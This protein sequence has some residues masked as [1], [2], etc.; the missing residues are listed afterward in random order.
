M[1][2]LNDV[3]LNSWRSITCIAGFKFALN[4]IQFFFSMFLRI[5]KSF[6]RNLSQIQS[7]WSMNNERHTQYYCFTY[8]KTMSI[9]LLF[10]PTSL[11]TTSNVHQLYPMFSTYLLT[12]FSDLSTYLSKSDMLSILSI[13]TSF[14]AF[15][16]ASFVRTLD[17]RLIFSAAMADG[18]LSFY[19]AIYG[20]IDLHASMV[21]LFLV[22]VLIITF[23]L[24]DSYEKKVSEKVR[25]NCRWSK[26]CRSF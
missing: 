13:L 17:M 4:N 3:K 15:L 2:L 20:I 9:T 14:V 21:A 23:P 8:A 6:W 24:I 5:N 10:R 19:I 25:W 7:I 12:F 22:V 18:L 16:P 11:L 1:I 26:H